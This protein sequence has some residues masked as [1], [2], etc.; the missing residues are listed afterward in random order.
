[1]PEVLTLKQLAEHLQLSERTIYRLLGRGQLPGFKLGG[2]WRFRRSVVDYWMDLRMGRFSPPELREMQAEWLA[3]PLI[4]SNALAVENAL[5]P[6]EPG[7]RR[8][9]IRRLVHSVSFSEPVDPDTVARRVWEREQLASTATEGGVAV[10]HT[11]RWDLRAMHRSDL[12]AIGRVTVG[13]DFGA[14]DGGPTDIFLLLLARD[15]RQHLILFAK[16]AQLCR[17]PGFLQQVRIAPSA[18]AVAALVRDTE[19]LLF[20]SFPPSPSM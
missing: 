4:L 13:V 7:S 6:L 17:E 10:L 3:A 19:R 11:A 16:A 15:A 5:L 8:E 18:T 9:I 2:H 14:A 20:A 12:L 1:M